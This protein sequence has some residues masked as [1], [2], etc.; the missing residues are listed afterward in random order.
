MTVASREVHV[1]SYPR[2]ELRDDDFAVVEV[3]VAD[4]RDGEVLVRNAFTSI[5]AALRIRL[6]ERAPAGYFASFP[7]DTAMDGIATVGEVV[8]SRA[9]GWGRG[10]LVQH[11]LGWR[12]LSVVPADHVFSV[13][14]GVAEPQR[15]LGVLGM[16]GLTAYVGL[17]DIAGLREG[18]VVFVS[19]AAGAVGSL[20][21]QLAKVRGHRVIGS[22][23]SPAKV[24]FVRDELGADVAFDYH[25]GP[26]AELLTEG[27]NVYFDNVGGEHLEAA[28]GAMHNHGRI[29][30]CGS[31]S[32]YNATSPAPGPRN[33]SLAT[34]KRLTLR[35]FIVRDHYD[36]RDAFLA[37]VAPLLADGRIVARE[38][39]VEGGLAAAP[40]AMIDLLAGGNT[41]K[42]LVRL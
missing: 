23:G 22:A 21:V 11:E 29:A 35:G 37:E 16:P 17:L 27:I 36:R 3:D 26:V 28:I 18:D 34:G 32:G 38:T 31:I 8:E 1:V 19:G 7:L 6:R 2:G 30:L 10:D 41:G 42:M 4:P 13:D 33:M 40:Q 9:D 15:F 24:A 20:V 25:D 39:V 5:D 14:P 12:E